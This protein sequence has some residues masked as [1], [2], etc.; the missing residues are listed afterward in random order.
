MEILSTSS[1]PGTSSGVQ[2]KIEMVFRLWSPAARSTD[3][4]DS[5]QGFTR[6]P[7]V[8]ALIED[9]VGARHATVL[10]G[11]EQLCVAGLKCASDALVV[12]RQIQQGLQGFRSM[13]GADP[14]ALS[15]AINSSAGL[16]N[17][18]NQEDGASGLSES[19]DH[20]VQPSHDLLSLLK[21]SKP[22]QIL[23]T[24]DLSEKIAAYKGLPLRSFAGRF[25]V[26]EYLWTSEEKL[27]LLQSEPQLTLTTIPALPQKPPTLPPPEPLHPADDREPAKEM[28]SA[29]PVFRSVETTE[30]NWRASLGDPKRLAAV[31]AA[32]VVFSAGLWGMYSA[33]RSVVKGPA[34]ASRETPVLQPQAPPPVRSNSSP[35]SRPSAATTPKTHPLTSAAS[36]PRVGAGSVPQV[37]TRSVTA[38]ARRSGCQLETSEIVGY[39]RRAEDMREGRR[40]SDATHL[41]EKVLACE[42]SNHEALT[43]LERTKTAA[44][45]EPQ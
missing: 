32:V 2:H 43:G 36:A 30:R 3:S 40:Y 31:A 23:V 18:E 14:V 8:L 7:G 35:P 16:S 24:H 38:D 29:F 12:S 45:Q 13:S 15:I 26:S 39:L 27:E 5:E 33:F 19:G 28:Y 9:V 44:E 22:A 6:F 20:D 10:A 11:K 17:P 25:G 21:L 4:A 37:S 42:P 34:P 1:P 41:Y